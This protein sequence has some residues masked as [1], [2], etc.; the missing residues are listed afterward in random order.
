[1]NSTFAHQLAWDLGVHQSDIGGVSDRN[2]VFFGKST[3][4][5]PSRGPRI[6]SHDVH[7][8]KVAEVGIWKVLQVEKT[9]GAAKTP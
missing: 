9:A 2:V 8:R 7:V 5:N 1:M 6:P 4:V 3:R